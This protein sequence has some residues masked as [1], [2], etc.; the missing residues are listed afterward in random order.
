MSSPEN[1]DQAV[2]AASPAHW[3]A[4][5]A[6]LT[7]VSA[8]LVWGFF[9][10]VPTRVH[11]DGIL[12][13]RGSEVFSAAAAG[14]GELVKVLVAVG[15]QV[16]AG[17][18][19]AELDQDADVKRLNV[20]QEKLARAERHLAEDVAE[21]RR[22]DAFHAAFQKRRRQ[23]I[24]EKT[25]H[26]RERHAKLR[27]LVDDLQGLFKRGY[28]QRTQLLDRENELIQVQESIAAMH[29]EVLELAKQERDR[30]TKWQ[31]RI[32]IAEKE[33]EKAG[34]D[35]NDVRQQLARNRTI[36]SPTDGIVT[37]ISASLG[38]VVAVG[39]PVVRVV[40]AAA[41]MEALLFIDSAEGKLV[42]PGYAVNIEP[43]VVKKE[44]HGT[45]LGTIRIVSH[46]P[47]SAAALQAMLQ[48]EKLV[49]RFTKKGSPVAVRALLSDG[50]DEHDHLQW[51]GGH[52]P[53]FTIEP[54]TLAT[55]TITVRRQRPVSLILPFLRS[56]LGI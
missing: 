8:A 56:F 20:A 29:N 36:H 33:V 43:S 22:D 49:E 12:L 18:T 31:Q 10:S 24:E 16:Q 45:I 26:A 39:T 47:M 23:A 14:G 38:D 11:A 55:A 53:G 30:I 5:A 1:L 48:N 21:K 41:E 4:F 51:S 27:A 7:L 50:D 42:K 32:R 17:Q 19:V 2:V 13:Q 28:I 9:G 52:G 54:G 15:D 37:E 25:D 40:S 46:L 35:L 6:C 3:L 34:H 44:E